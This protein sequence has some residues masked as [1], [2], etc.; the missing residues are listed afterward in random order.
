MTTRLESC[1]VRVESPNGLPQGTGFV[2]SPTLVVTCAHVVEKCRIGS[3]ERLCLTFH[4]D[5]SAI[6]AEVLADGLH[7]HED[8]A[9]LRIVGSLPR[10]ITPGALGPSDGTEDNRFRTLGSPLMGDFRGVRASG[11][12]LG[13]VTDETGAV[14][15]QL[16]S[17]EIAPGMSGAPVIDV[18]V[19]RVVGMVK[20]AYNP[21]GTL[22]FR[23]TAFAVP[24][25]T[26]HLLRPWEV[27]LESRPT[28]CTA[29]PLPTNFVSRT[30]EL[31]EL[32]RIVL[33]D[34]A[35]RQIALTAL[36]GM[37]GIGKTVLALALC[38]DEAIQAA[39]PDGIFWV[40]IGREPGDLVKQM[41][42]I[43]TALGDIP[44]HYDSPEAGINRLRVILPDK[45]TLIVLDDVWDAQHVEPFW[46][47]AP[48]CCLLFT[49]RDRRVGLRLGAKEVRLDVLKP[50]EALALLRQWAQRDDPAFADLAERLG[51]LPLALELAGARLRE[52]MSGAEWLKTFRH[53][54]QIKLGRDS[55]DPKENL[56]VCF[57][58]STERL[59]ENDCALY[60]TIGIFPEDVWIPQPVVIRLWRQVNG[61]MTD[62]DCQQ[63]VIDLERLALIQVNEERSVTLHDLLHDYTRTKLGDCYQTT[64]NELL[65]AYNPNSQPWYEIKH[66]GYLYYQLPYHMIEAGRKDELYSLLTTAPSW[67][68]AR[69]SK[70]RDLTVENLIVSVWELYRQDD[71]KTAHHFLTKWLKRRR[72]ISRSGFTSKLVAV[73]CAFYVGD[74]EALTLALRGREERLRT[75]AVTYAYFHYRQNPDSVFDNILEPLAKRT[76]RFGIPNAKLIQTVLELILLLLI[77]EYTD[78]GPNTHNSV[79]LIR[80]GEGVVKDALY[81]NSR[82]PRS[83]IRRIRKTMFNVAVTYV[84]RRLARQVDPDDALDTVVTVN[85]LENF[86]KHIQKEDAPIKKVL[87]YYNRDYGDLAVAVDSVVAVYDSTRYEYSSAFPAVLTGQI[88]TIH[89][90]RD[91]DHILP[92]LRAISSLEEPGIREE[93]QMHIAFV[94]RDILVHKDKIEDRWLDAASD[95]TRTYYD[96]AT[97]GYGI[98]I[99]AG[100]AYEYFPMAHYSQVWNRRYP[101]EPVDLVREYLER[102]EHAGDRELITH[103]LRGFSDQRAHLI[104][105][106][107]VLR[108]FTPYLVSEDA[109]LRNAAIRTVARI[110]SRHQEQVDDYLAEANIPHQDVIAIIKE[111]SYTESLQAVTRQI[112]ALVVAVLA[113]IPPNELSWLFDGMN[114]AFS[115]GNIRDA[116]NAF[117]DIVVNTLEGDEQKV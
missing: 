8:V 35:K 28:V 13:Q 23:D 57:D 29:P 36:E 106:R 83:V 19:N 53:V 42:S 103:I 113:Y 82:V 5:G 24:A 81:V 102:A 58:L 65:T 92:V 45:A 80:I 66:E 39:F 51:Y 38:H 68:E 94:W 108:Q 95:F 115:Q 22:K 6:E 31:D 88:I 114:A 10:G 91:P 4:Y 104:E 1:I 109:E 73:R 93:R 111:L 33:G 60:Y 21:D 74:D 20:L 77:H 107:A 98:V 61:Q 46:T 47:T 2:V 96:N 25:E 3:G 101:S 27:E 116:L 17:R 59:P 89:G 67:I 70:E 56:Q 79:R 71:E 18:T 26:L 14:M 76:K 64:Q 44:E 117:F 78:E 34:A 32:R 43:G 37:G 52:G 99:V 54:S 15:L 11:D 86:F 55:T 12:I 110:R 75:S 63:L 105:Y 62:F 112:G 30:E 90:I 85:D 7:S 84:M 72:G 87:P 16:R 97:Q 49:T 48:R 50:E 100:S 40:K 69:F 41:K 9:F